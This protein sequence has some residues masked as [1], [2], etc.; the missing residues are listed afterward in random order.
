MQSKPFLSLLPEE[1]QYWCNLFVFVLFCLLFRQLWIAYI[2]FACNTISVYYVYMKLECGFNANCMLPDTSF[3]SSYIVYIKNTD[4]QFPCEFISK[5]KLS[6]CIIYGNWNRIFKQIKKRR[7]YFEQ[8]MNF[9]Q[10]QRQQKQQWGR[11]Y[12]MRK[13]LGFP[14]VTTFN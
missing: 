14:Y 10:R 4:C 5:R 12:E 9:I 2:P 6:L 1:F 3:F 7:L 13:M 11:V 8:D